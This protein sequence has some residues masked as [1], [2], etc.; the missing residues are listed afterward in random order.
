MAE[1]ETIASFTASGA[2]SGNLNGWTINGTPSYGTSGGGFYQL[3][4]S[5]ISIVTPSIK[6]SD[7][8][9]ITI[10][11][12]ARKY[13]GPNATQGKISVSQGSTELTS[14]SPSGTSIA[15]SSALEISPNDG[16]ITI[17][18]PGA[19][20]N[21][22]C[23]VQSIVIKGTKKTS[24][25]PLAS[26]ALSGT[27]PTQFFYGD[28]FSHEGMTVTATYEDNTT[29]DVT[30]SATFSGYSKTSYGEQEITV[31]YSE[32]EITK[33]AKYDIIIP[34]LNSISISGSYPTTFTEGDEFSHEGMV[35]T[36]NYI[37]G[38]NN[39][40]S[41]DVTE[42]TENIFFW[43]YD[44]SV[45]AV[46]NVTVAYS[47]GE[48]SKT[49][50][51]TITV[52]AIPEHSV[53]WIVNGSINSQQY[54]E[55]ATVIFPTDPAAIGDK[56]FVG[57]TTTPIEGITDIAPTFVTS[58]TMGDADI[59]LYAVFATVE[60]TS[61]EASTEITGSTAGL[62]TSYGNANTFSEYTLNGIKYAIQQM[63]KSGGKLQWRAGGHNSGTG[64]MYNM[65]AF[66]TIKSVVLTY[67]SS[68]SYKNFTLKVGNDKNP[69]GGTAITPV[70]NEN[71]YTF[72]C[73]S[74]NCSYF[75][76]ANGTNAGYLDKI[77]INYTTGSQT[78]SGYCT[79]VAADTREEAGLGF[80]ESTATVEWYVAAQ[81]TGQA[82]TNPYSVSPIT[83][84]SSN[85]GVATV[86]NGTVT[87]L[88]LGETTIKA[89]FDGDENYKKGEASYTLTVVDNRQTATVTWKDADG[90]NITELNVEKG[91]FIQGI[92]LSCN[93][94]GFTF[95]E[96]HLQHLWGTNE[97]HDNY[98]GLQPAGYIFTP[99]AVWT[100]ALGI[101]TITATFPGNETHKPASATLTV[102]VTG[103]TV[104]TPYTVAEAI[105]ATPASGTTDNVYIKGIVSQFYNTSIVGDGSNYR[106]YISDDGTKTT[107]LLVYK[108]KGLNNTAFANAD[109]LQIGDEVVI[110][111]GLTTYNNAPE[112]ASGNYIVSL[113][114]KPAAPTFSPAAGTYTSTQY[115]TISAAEGAA[116]YYTTD[117]TDP[118]TES[119]QYSGPIAVNESMTIKAIAVKDSQ[120]SDVATAVYDIDLSPV[121]TV[122]SP[123]EL[124]GN[125]PSKNITISYNNFTP[126]SDDFGVVY[127]DENGDELSGGYDWI[128]KITQW[129]DETPNTATMIFMF[130]PN[131][132]S[133]PRTAYMKIYAMNGN[134]RV[135][136]ELITITQEVYVE[137]TKVSFYVNG[138]PIQYSYLEEGDPIEFP[139]VSNIDGMTFLGWTSTEINGTTDTA[140]EFVDVTSAKMGTESIDYYA[141]F[142]MVSEGLFK[143]T[144]GDTFTAGDKIVIVANVDDETAYGLYQE[145]ISNSY[146]NNFTFDGSYATVKD[147]DKTWWTVSAGSD[148][149]WKLGDATN[150]YLYSSGSNNLSVDKNNSSQWTLVDN[151]N[152]T[153]GLTQGRYL[154]CRS[155]LS[156]TNQYLFRL[157]GGTPAGIYSLDIYKT[158]SKSDYCTTIP[159]M[160]TITIAEACTDGSKYYGTYS[161]SSAFKV[162]V[163][164][165]VSEIGINYDDGTMNVQNYD[166][167]A[168]VP[169]NTGVMVSATTFG[170]H[171]LIKSSEEGTS[172]LGDDN[173]LRPTG[174]DGIT[175][176][177]MDNKDSN[178]KFY[179]LTMHN[180]TDI[181]FWWGYENGGAF[182]VAANKA[183][184]VVPAGLAGARQGFGFDDATTGISNVNVNENVNGNVYDLQG[185]KV[186]TPTKGLYIVNGKKVVIK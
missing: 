182:A 76:L 73:S 89:S 153:F 137:P 184:M 57:W 47:E 106:Y 101:T 116:I 150:G 52:N 78:V 120:I 126:E 119:T 80:V 135:Y 38:D 167:G 31:S 160:L 7:Y 4:N 168:V 58:A 11:I 97:T 54:K 109:D 35:V 142:A 164:V 111:G 39:E 117:G 22:G 162:P 34:T 15:A 179:R 61:V 124:D 92:T 136:S 71:V 110:C 158:E 3:T 100:A 82:L 41:R 96:E 24:T 50:N 77:T 56:V 114:R 112:V 26:I 102:N 140:P 123:I 105:A 40:Y 113:V 144:T 81:Y 25:S 67:N 143:M 74:A 37:D 132:G 84:T 131:T 44:I 171:K 5:N 21:K 85:E 88:A 165:T 127:C 93:V 16:T 169:A 64:T 130:D 30:N 166:S 72:D 125:T 99:N 122:A 178:S 53:V 43:G 180:G 128:E 156:G 138:G 148:G 6:W 69:T 95:T 146:V 70:Q 75:V 107:Q 141:V 174:D 91:D 183:Y 66:Q 90:N 170:E 27:Y 8:S 2:N 139:E 42:K 1:E 161:S 181:G 10:T 65:D 68:D 118:T 129:I 186:N 155:D 36:A 173:R 29:K 94:E 159:A 134:D 51:Y 49:A 108:G 46:Q 18:C 28:E 59:F 157:A 17:S 149:K 104:T 147:D 87:V 151:E 63:Y 145:T 98:D 23:G 14:Y 177:E 79:T 19:S 154:S 62:P 175:A 13:G 45:P 185:R 115:V 9:D 172:V 55:G 48:T 32:G 12:S 163:N 152:D 133:A 103:G 86:E 176:D 33:E 83:W 60:G 121:I 20:S